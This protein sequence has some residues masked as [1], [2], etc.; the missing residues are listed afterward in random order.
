VA[1][2]LGC[3]IAPR[4]YQLGLLSA[5]DAIVHGDR[6]CDACARAPRD[7]APE[8]F[9]RLL[10]AADGNPLGAVVRALADPMSWRSFLK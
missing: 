10:R 9:A 8:L 3:T 4:S 7:E 1:R 6:G 5:A 2:L